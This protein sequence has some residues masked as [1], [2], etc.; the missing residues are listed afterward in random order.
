M[1]LHTQLYER[2]YLMKKF[3]RV[4][5]LL[6]ALSFVLTAFAAC[7]EKE[8][9]TTTKPSK[10][11]TA[12]QN[13]DDPPDK[14]KDISFKG[15]K[16]HIW[17]NDFIA[18]P[19]IRLANVNPCIDYM[20]G[21]DDTDE[22]AANTVLAEA[23]ERYDRVLSILGL[24]KD[25]VQYT[26]TGWKGN[27]NT[28]LSDI[29]AMVTA[30]QKDGPSLIIHANYGLVRAG[31]TGLLYNVYDK[32]Q[33]NYFDLT[34][35]GWYLDMMEENTIDKNKIYMLF[36]DFF[37]D[38]FRMSYGVL[39]NT[40]RIEERYRPGGTAGG[41]AALFAHVLD[42]FWTYDTMMEIADVCR[43]DNGGDWNNLSIMGAIG[44]TSWCVRPLFATSG[45]DI[46]QRD[47]NGKVTYRADVRELHDW[48]D[49]LINMEKE[50]WFAY[51][52][53][54]T[55]HSSSPALNPNKDT[56]STTFA[57]GRAAFALGQA[58]ATFESPLIQNMHDNCAFLPTP[59]YHEEVEST[60]FD[61]IKKLYGALTSDVANSGGILITAKP[62]DFTLSS[63]FLQ[64]MAENSESFME[65]YYET[66]LMIKVNQSNSQ[67]QMQMI[68]IVHDG[69]CSPMSMLY[70]NY[71][72][73]STSG[74]RT[75]S[76]IM[77]DSL[78]KQS[79]TFVSD[80]ESELG[81]RTAQWEKLVTNFGKRT[82]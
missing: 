3:L 46:F 30:N 41:T 32:D 27:G 50:P 38:Q 34:D 82:D 69:L 66:N 26:P 73:Q 14:W 35:K 47:E 7:G 33:D 23:T 25:D 39:A 51:N 36:G 67:Q 81:P 15:Q 2:V 24:E 57:E 72:A 20:R 5:C 76:S 31:I 10:T 54:D 71:C 37:I 53:E 28:V 62:E 63:A 61:D 17:I 75:F 19:N 29:R 6:L 79:N 11:T 77:C 60:E 8:T 18:D 52:W 59:R 58:V 22:T 78:D 40:T 42:G 70:D 74:I 45:L 64:L 13:Q 49:T 48:L 55:E 56:A 80:W 68:R 65:E 44:P 1:G 43:Q 12:S 9:D 4:F 21:L 16:L